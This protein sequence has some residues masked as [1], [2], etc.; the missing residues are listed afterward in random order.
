MPEYQIRMCHCLCSHYSDLFLEIAGWAPTALSSRPPNVMHT[1]REY[2]SDSEI[3]QQLTCVEA[4]EGNAF[5]DPSDELR[6][7]WQQTFS[8]G[9]Q[10]PAADRRPPVKRRWSCQL[11][12]VV[13]STEFNLSNHMRRH[14]AR[15]RHACPLCPVTCST[16]FNLGSHMRTHTGE[17]PFQCEMCPMA[18]AAKGTLVNHR[19]THTGER[20][21]KCPFCHKGFTRKFVL[22]DHITYRHAAERANDRS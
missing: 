7:E 12:P 9:G 19:R 6:L 15:R 5:A 16:E 13:C 17:K 14:A 18:F 21:F 2:S 11:C 22:R 8:A 4:P 3:I 10:P 1:S 20:P